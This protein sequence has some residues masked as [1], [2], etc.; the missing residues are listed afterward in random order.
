MSD[1]DDLIPVATACRILGGDDSPLNPSTVWRWVKAGKISPP[2]KLGP[3]TARFSRRK[4]V[5][6]R[7]AMASAH[8]A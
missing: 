6:E 5:A 8:A 7:D 3:G 2:I 4:L 1:T